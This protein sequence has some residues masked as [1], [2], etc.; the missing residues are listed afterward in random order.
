[1]TTVYAEFFLLR[2]GGRAGLYLVINQ[3][4]E[5]VSGIPADHHAFGLTDEEIEKGTGIEAGKYPLS[6]DLDRRIMAHEVALDDFMA[7]VFCLCA[8]KI[9]TADIDN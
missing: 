4:G 6:V 9:G 7:H 2:K 3:N 5:D 8:G 1:M